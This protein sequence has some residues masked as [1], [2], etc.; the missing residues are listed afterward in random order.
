MNSDA[1]IA[2]IFY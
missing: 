1:V 2:K